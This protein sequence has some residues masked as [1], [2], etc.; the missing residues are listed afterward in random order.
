MVSVL[1]KLI[2]ILML[3]ITTLRAE[4]NNKTLAVLV[5][6]NDPES[7]EIAEYYQRARLIPEDNIIYLNFKNNINSLTETE[8]TQIESQL[9]TK[10]TSNIQ[11]YALAWRKPWRV[12]CMSITSAFSLGFSKEFC[13]V[14]CNLTKAVSYFNS[15]SARPFTDYGIRPS[16]LLSAN[17]VD[18]VKKLIDRGVESDY[19]R[20]KATAYLVSTSDK[21]R[22]VRALYY[23]RIKKKLSQLLSVEVV[24]A[25]AIKNKRNVMFYFTGL[26]KVKFI[27]ANNYVPGAI[28]DHLTSTGGALFNGSQMSVLEWVESGVTGTYGTVVEPCNYTQ[29]FPNPGI[30][31]QRYLSGSSL[32]EAYWKSVKMPGQGLFIGEPLAS[33]YKGC[34]YQLD[35][36]GEYRYD[37]REP[38]NLVE[39]IAK[40]CH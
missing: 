39:R 27:N 34:K 3:S 13:S 6:K 33:P 22:N 17:S 36:Q 15:R 32:V 4:I 12:G 11:A 10:V 1:S 25:D 35:A 16:M 28:A 26:D 38:D 20:P 19:T 18:A 2:V 37:I 24:K 7:M 31:M 29:K 14:A 5:N 8:F 30:V 21:Q 23:P 9:K 40:N